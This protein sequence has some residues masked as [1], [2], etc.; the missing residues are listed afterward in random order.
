MRASDVMAT[1]VVTIDQNSTVGQLARLL[2]DNYISGAPVIDESGRVVGMISEGDLI[3]R[4]EIDTDSGPS[5]WLAWFSTGTERARDF[6][7]THSAYATDVMTHPAI[8]VSPDTPLADIARTM[9]KRRVKRVPVIENGK[10]VGLVSRADLLR[11]LASR[12]A[13]EPRAPDSADAAVR[14]AVIEMLAEEQDW[15]GSAMINVIVSDGTAHLWGV[16]DNETQ[17]RALVVAAEGVPGVRGVEDHLGRS[18]P[19]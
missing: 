9:E 14:E 8:T 2:V 15:A 18:L 19:T 3:R 10:L 11:A 5:G 4:A 6:L 16:V 12:A 1:H 17:R 13:I 7:K